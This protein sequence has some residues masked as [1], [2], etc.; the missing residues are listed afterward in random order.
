ML[1]EQ[2][3]KPNCIT[4]ER[5]YNQSHFDVGLFGDFGTHSFHKSGSPCQDTSLPG[6]PLDPLDLENREEVRATSLE[7][8]FPTPGGAFL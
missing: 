3:Q 5:R 1:S 2:E 6:I 4:F 7:V 8:G